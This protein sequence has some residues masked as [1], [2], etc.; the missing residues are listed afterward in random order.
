M[1]S[2]RVT[3]IP[4]REKLEK[5]LSRFDRGS[6]SRLAQKLVDEF[7]LEP[8]GRKTFADQMRARFGSELTAQQEF[9]LGALRSVFEAEQEEEEDE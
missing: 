4:P 5:I 7:D 3:S 1:A 6:K 9:Q 8:E 2:H